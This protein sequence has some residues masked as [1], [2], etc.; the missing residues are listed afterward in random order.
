MGGWVGGTDA[1]G[2]HTSKSYDGWVGGCVAALRTSAHPSPPPLQL[3]HHCKL[4]Q[5]SVRCTTPHT[6]RPGRRICPIRYCNVFPATWR[7]FRGGAAIV[8]ATASTVIRTR[9]RGT[10][11][12][13]LLQIAVGVVGARILALLGVVFVSSQLRFLSSAS[14]LRRIVGSAVCLLRNAIPL[15]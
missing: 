7:S 15:L 10:G 3:S 9:T 12:L 11:D 1:I 5:K 6:D 2:R 4:S 13:A 8:Y 14:R